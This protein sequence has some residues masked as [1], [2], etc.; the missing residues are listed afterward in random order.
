MKHILGVDV[1]PTNNEQ[2]LH[3]FDTSVYAEGL[4]VTCKRLEVNIPGFKKAKLIEPDSHFNL[5]LNGVDLGIIDPETTELP[6]LPDGFYHIKYSVSP[7][8]LVFVEFDYLRTVSFNK[9]LF[10]LRCG[11][12][13]GSC[14]PSESIHKKLKLFGE[15][16]DY[17]KAAI[18]SVEYCDDVDRGLE[19]FIY[20]KKLLDRS[21]YC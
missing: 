11:L 7:N 3:L 1:I 5:A 15:I 10:K 14:I 8:E 6:A 13:M 12:Q 4:G 19:L 18:A 2:I 9:E 20:A 17:L 16:E 21:S